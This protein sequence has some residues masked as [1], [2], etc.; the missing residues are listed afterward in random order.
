[1]KSHYAKEY[2]KIRIIN[3]KDL[4]LEAALAKLSYL[5]G[6]VNF[7]KAYKLYSIFYVLVR[8]IILKKSKKKWIKV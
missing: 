3:G 8:D 2:E 1:M 4:T 5:L 7:F 6:K